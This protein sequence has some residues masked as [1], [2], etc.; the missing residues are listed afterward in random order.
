MESPANVKFTPYQKRLFVFLSVATFFEGYD[1]MALAQILPNLRADMDLTRTQAGVLITV[2]NFGTMVAYLLVRRADQWGRRRVLT[3]TI[4]GYTIFTFLTGFTN[5]VWTFAIFQFIARV[6]LIAEWAVSFVIAAEEFPAARRGMVIG[7][8]SAFSSLGAI[9]CAGTAPFLLDTEYGWRTV[10][11]VGIIPLILLAFARR[12]LRETERFT[13]EVGKDSAQKS[14]WH[15]F[16]TPY[17]SRLLKVSLIWFVGYIATQNAVTFW[18]DFA[19]NERGWTDAMVGQAIP[20]AAI[21]AMPLVFA[22]GKLCDVIGR[23][24]GAAVIF[25]LGA[26]GTYA[27]YTAEGFWPLTAALVFGIFSASG[28]LPVMNAFTT[29]LFPTALRGDAF[30]WANNIFGRTAYVLSPL[31]VGY[32]ADL[33]IAG[34]RLGFGPVLSATAIFPLIAIVL[35][36]WLLPETKGSE[37]DETAKL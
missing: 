16:S 37:L 15:I 3:L 28:F 18:K 26:I 5:N 32:F 7:V 2:V 21:L 1:F 11:F 35:V 8:I 9:V 23:K 27:C 29:E 30:A 17:R 33:E 22:A 20:L 19:L 4:A 6:F 12:N 31:A 36:F 14:L 10:Y 13:N 25:T 24:P 34:Q